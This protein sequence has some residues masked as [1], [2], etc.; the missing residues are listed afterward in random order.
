[1]AAMTSQGTSMVQE[2]IDPHLFVALSE[3]TVVWWE[4]TTRW[5]RSS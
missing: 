4:E 1:M 3:I 2:R 5:P